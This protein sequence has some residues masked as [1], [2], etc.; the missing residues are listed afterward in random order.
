[1]ICCARVDIDAGVM[2]EASG[3]FLVK[4]DADGFD[5]TA[6]SFQF[7]VRP[8]N[9]V[10]REVSGR[11][12]SFCNAPLPPRTCSGAQCART[13]ACVACRLHPM[14]LLTRTTSDAGPSSS[15]ALLAILL[16]P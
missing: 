4:V 9:L 3:R 11:R 7:S 10:E 15:A 2:E 1:M 6:V 12:M 14:M 8:V 13:K 16:Q 5:S